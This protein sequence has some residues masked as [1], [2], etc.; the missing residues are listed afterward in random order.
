MLNLL[1][2][3]N[4]N[5]SICTYDG[6]EFSSVSTIPTANIQELDFDAK[7]P[8]AVASVAPEASELLRRGNNV[9]SLDTTKETGINLSMIDKSTLGADR[10]ANAIALNSYCKLP[11]ICIDFGTAITFEVVDEHSY[12]RGGAILPGRS[13][14]RKS[15]SQ[16]TSQLPFTE[17]DDNSLL[18]IGRNTIDAIKLGIDGGVCG[19][20]REVL[21]LIEQEIDNKCS[22][23]A[24]GGDSSFFKKLIPDIELE[25]KMF[26]FKGLLKVWEMNQ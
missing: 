22:V 9:F 12:F 20:V 18:S 15:L 10:L 2:I 24:T 8:L 4:T 16:N 26:T 13:L 6:K 7:L 1:N 19:M 21:K 14:L 11:G 3:G 5:A 25:D 17:P 23:I